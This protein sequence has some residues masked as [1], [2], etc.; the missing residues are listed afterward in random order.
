MWRRRRAGGG[1]GVHLEGRSVFHGPAVW[2]ASS[3]RQ[4]QKELD[5]SG[6]Y[7]LSASGPL[8]LF[9]KELNAPNDIAF[10]P[11]EKKV[12]ISNADPR[13]AVWMVYDVK[14]DGTFTNGRV[15]F[16]AIAWTKTK[17]RAPDG[18]KVDGVGNLVAAGPGG[19]H[20]FAPD[21]TH[22]GSM[23]T[24]AATANCA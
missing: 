1:G 24:G 2:F 19:S 15:F 6:G 9:T 12:Y 21:G 16:D 11:D 23:E 13:N 5:F 20:V 8:T 4:P 10:S 3:V 14:D 22:L 17:K 18:M 7:R